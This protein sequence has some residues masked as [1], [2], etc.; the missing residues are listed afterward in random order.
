MKL[1]CRLFW[2]STA[3]YFSVISSV[4]AKDYLVTNT[5]VYTSSQK[6]TF[7]NVDIFISD[8][9]IMEVGSNLKISSK[10]TH[11]DGTGKYLTPGLMNASTQLGLEEISAAESTVDHHTQMKSYSAS[12]EIAPA[13]NTKSTLI[14]HNRINGITRVIVAP[15]GNKLF[16]GIASSLILAGPTNEVV[17]SGIAQFANYGDAGA[18]MAGGSRASAYLAIDRAL[19]EA[20]YLRNNRTQFL[21]GQS[22]NFSLSVQDLDALK[23][24]LEKKIPLVISAHRS[25]DILALLK[26]AKKYKIKL[27]ISGGAEAWMVANELALAKV[28]VIMDPMLNLPNSFEALG[29]K[30]E[31]AAILNEAGVKLLFTNFSSHNAYLVR[32]SAGNAVAYG[33]DTDEAIRAMTINIAEVFGIKNYGKIELGMEADLVLWDGDPLELTSNAEMV[34]VKGNLQP[35]VSRASRLKDRF[36]DLSNIETKAYQH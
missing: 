9:F 29:A 24:V 7:K 32:Q 34:L 16:T 23:P 31:S 35:M 26:L 20:D 11:I 33:L 30:L 25:G 4:S 15:T 36:W 18:Q 28:P 21:P 3:L 8:G 2:F 19:Q 27:V 17:E 5:T 22:H 6:G 14:P 13:I 12:F 10:H 1:L